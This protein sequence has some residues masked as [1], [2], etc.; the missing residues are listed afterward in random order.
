MENT[1]ELTLWG[2]FKNI[3][4]AV[5]TVS[6]GMGITFKYVYSVKPVTI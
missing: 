1:N 4:T 3:W 2:W 5:R 6:K